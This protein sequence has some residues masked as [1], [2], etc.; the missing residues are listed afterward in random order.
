MLQEGGKGRHTL[1]GDE[2]SSKQASNA[3]IA[4][5]GIW[6]AEEEKKESARCGL[7]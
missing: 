4:A 2:P 5:K 3:M 1:S 7:M 6:E